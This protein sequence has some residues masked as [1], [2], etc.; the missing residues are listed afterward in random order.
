MSKSD[1]NVLALLP[2]LVK[3]ALS[4]EIFRAMPTRGLDITVAYSEDTSALYPADDMADFQERNRLV[5]LSTH[6]VPAKLEVINDL[7]RTREIDLI[8]QVGAHDL[9]HHLGRWKE[10]TPSLRIAD[11][12]YNEF[13]HTQNHFLY[14][15]C[16]DGV[17]V[18]SESM[19]EYVVRAS[20]RSSP[21]VRIVRSGVDLEWFAPL[22]DR[23]TSGASLTLGFIGRMSP[24]KNPL[25]FVDLAERLLPLDPSLR[26]RMYGG[27]DQ[28]D[29][30][31]QRLAG[32]PSK[33]QIVYGGFIEHSRKALHEFDALVLP[34]KFDGR[35]AIIMEAN[36]CGVPVIAAPVGG[37]PEL[38]EEGI[39]GHLIAPTD[40]RAIHALLTRWKHDPNALA[41]LKQSSR[42]HAV[43]RFDRARML[44][45]YAEAFKAIAG[46]PSSWP[47]P[48]G[49][50][51]ET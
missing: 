47:T 31:R 7:V 10:Q 13:G 21:P 40:V 16:I 2:F 33:D 5:D 25:G 48:D 36:A 30:V 22:P 23:D 35:P 28:A 3:G 34:S 39:N 8:V 46:A 15:R 9:Y 18:E 44:D 45:D 42:E 49:V 20:S 32:S 11:I 24:E 38:I 43:Q 1:R 6:S 26:F 12:L 51:R 27:G 14:E 17:I 50:H 4:I 29:A 41:A 19:R 37:V